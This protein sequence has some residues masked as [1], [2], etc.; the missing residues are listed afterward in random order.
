M[1]IGIGIYDI[2]NATDE[3]AQTLCNKKIEQILPKS[4]E[5]IIKINRHQP[6]SEAP[7]SNNNH[8]MSAD[9]F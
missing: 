4:T 9:S 6:S 2:L 8:K 5:Q 1:D 3:G 7:R